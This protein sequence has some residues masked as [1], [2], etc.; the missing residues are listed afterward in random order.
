MKVAALFG[1]GLNGVIGTQEVSDQDAGEQGTED[2]PDGWPVS[3]KTGYIKPSVRPMM[4][5]TP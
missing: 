4:I 5:R 2:L 3:L 1:Q